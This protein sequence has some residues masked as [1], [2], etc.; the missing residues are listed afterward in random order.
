[1]PTRRHRG[2]VR[3]SRRT[4]ELAVAVPQVVMH[5]LGRAALAGS[6]PS[7]RDRREFERMYVEKI[8]AFNEACSA[9]AMETVRASV[10]GFFAPWSWPRSAH[11]STHA[12]HLASLYAR[13]GIG[14]VDQAMAPY[15]RRAVANARRLARV[16]VR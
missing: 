1:M 4:L 13:M 11:A 8:A 5:R 16:R 15:H 12:M 10:R 7:S 14:M 9:L 2:A 3:N 6:P